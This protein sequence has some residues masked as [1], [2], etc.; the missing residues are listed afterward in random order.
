M[1]HRADR[2]LRHSLSFVLGASLSVSFLN[3][4]E[5]TVR[6][7]EIDASIS[8][9][10]FDGNFEDTEPDVI[11]DQDA[12]L[13]RARPP[14]VTIF[15]IGC[16]GERPLVN[17]Q[18]PQPDGGIYGRCREDGELINAK[19]LGAYCCN[20]GDADGRGYTVTSKVLSDA[21]DC[22]QNAP[23][24]ILICSIC[25]DGNCSAWENRC[26]CSRDCQ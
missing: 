15:C 16:P 17:C 9:G 7:G 6:P 26:N 10:G 11:F 22:I 14:G 23:D 18:P 19:V 21:G 1:E 4:T 25:G 20:K 2:S 12:C 3:C 13:D 5:T 24:D 8:D